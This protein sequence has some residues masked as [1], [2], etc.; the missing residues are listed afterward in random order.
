M[1]TRDRTPRPKSSGYI[2]PEG[3][4]RLR[5]E[6]EQLWTVERPRVT[7]EVADAAAQGDRSENAEYIYGKRRLREIDRRVRFLSKRLDELVVVSEPPSD[8]SRVFF[9]AWVTIEDE[10]GAEAV[11][12]IVGP[13]EFDTDR[14]WI[15]LDSPVARALMGKREGDEVTVHRPK[16]ET[17]YTIAR[18]GY[19]EPASRRP[20]S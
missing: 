11:Y 1:S 10:D 18:V 3:A 19:H 7:Q 14:G 17:T 16:G 15:S 20:A 13:D 8:A 12:R 6:L 9:G 5:D 2:T 4:K